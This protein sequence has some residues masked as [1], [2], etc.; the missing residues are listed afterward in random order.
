MRFDF[1]ALIADAEVISGN[2]DDVTGCAVDFHVFAGEG[3]IPGGHDHGLGF[4]VAEDDGGVVVYVWVGRGLVGLHD[5]CDAERGLAMHEEGGE[6]GSVAA[7][8]EEGARAVLDGIGEPRE[9]LGAYADLFGALV[10]VV[11][12]DFA[13]IAELAGF[14]FVDG[15]GVGGVPGGFVVDQDVDVMLASGGADGEGVFHGGRE[16]L[17][18]HGADIVAGRGFDD[19][20]VIL[21]GGVDEYGVGV[22]GGEHVLEVGV[23][24]G[25]LQ[26]VLG[27]VLL[28]EGGVGFDDGDE[29][30]RGVF[31]ES[32]EEAFH[33]SVNEADDGDTDGFG[34]T[35]TLCAKRRRCD[36]EKENGRD[37][38]SHCGLM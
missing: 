9:P 32:A 27:G 6:V 3:P 5:G 20:A 21:N 13:E 16:G 37:E 29:L 28:R 19:A 25:L 10:A 14:G 26:V 11:D 33:V 1:F 23:E 35:D 36:C 24:E 22:L 38:E 7:E 4:G 18:D 2:R 31:G 34:G 15:F 17:L 8:V 30:G 12:D